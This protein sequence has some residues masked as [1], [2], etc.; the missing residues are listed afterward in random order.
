M[1]TPIKRRLQLLSL[2]IIALLL[3]ICM[4]TLFVACN[5]TNDNRNANRNSTTLIDHIEHFTGDIILDHVDACT[6]EFS[7]YLFSSESALYSS[8]SDTYGEGIYAFYKIFNI[9][10]LSYV[11]FY[12]SSEH[13]SDAYQRHANGFTVNGEH[14]NLSLRGNV[15]VTNGE[16]YD[17][18][19]S[20][21]VSTEF[22]SSNLHK[23]TKNIINSVLNENDYDNIYFA[24]FHKSLN[25]ELSSSFGLYKTPLI[26]NCAERYC[27]ST[28]NGNDAESSFG[29]N[30]KEIQNQIG[31][32]YSDDSFAKIED[33]VVL[34][35]TKPKLGFRFE[36]L[37]IYGFA[38]TNYYYDTENNHAVIPS[39]YGGRPVIE[40]GASA[41]S[42]NGLTSVTIPATVERI[43]T[44]AF[45]NCP[46]LKSVA[47]AEGNPFYFSAGN[48][49]I[50]TGHQQTLIIGFAN[51]I[52]PTDGRVARIGDYAF[53][54]CK[55]LK[56]ITI[57]RGVT[58]IGMSAFIRCKGL[59]SIYIPNSVTAI[60]TDAFK[61]CHNLEKINFGGTMEKWK[62]ISK[63]QHTWDLAEDFVVHCADGTLDKD[64]NEI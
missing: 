53:Q 58:Y 38:V 5:N 56:T 51:S 47:V 41:F 14:P 37:G 52:I 48:C 57:P 30:I 8:Y 40:I 20:S 44:S 39:D 54:D 45:I 62:A 13:A 64:G 25:G 18:M 36:Y 26:G 61:D 23:T 1:N 4:A 11:A 33:D 59:T 16:Y 34:I 21:T 46:T 60:E 22:T 42:G 32:E 19:M 9:A 50:E 35:S 12:D 10:N 3:V 15:I 7:G 28:Y 49:I 24:N 63:W 6:Y 27:V 43:S 31:T 2:C 55:D 29:Y 17:S